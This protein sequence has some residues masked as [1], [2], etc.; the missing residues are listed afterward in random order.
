M[1]ARQRQALAAA[2][3]RIRRRY[4]TFRFDVAQG[5]WQD[6]T[7]YSGTTHTGAGVVDLTY[8]GMVAGR[9]Y[10]Y[11][12]KQLRDVG[13]QAAFGRGPW[14]S[15][16]LHFHVVDLDT[17]GEDSNAAWQ[18]SE[19]RLGC[20]GLHAGVRDPFPYRPTPIRK[21]RYQ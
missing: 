7:W 2:E 4:W 9:K 14:C 16:P 18:A 1:T 20:D 6:E 21:W 10:R 3:R 13:R 8:P 19:Y 5:S 12:L 11:V 15:M 17:L